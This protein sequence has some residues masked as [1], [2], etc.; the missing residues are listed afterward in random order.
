MSTWYFSFA[1]SDLPKGTQFLGA[2]I[3]RLNE[4]EAWAIPEFAQGKGADDLARAITKT[5]VLGINPGGG[6][7]SVRLPDVTDD[8]LAQWGNRLLTRAEAEA[9]PKPVFA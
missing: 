5:H 8:Y 7:Q 3:V 1:D 2:C 6:V 4:D 9:L